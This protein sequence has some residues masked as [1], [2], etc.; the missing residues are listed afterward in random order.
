MCIYEVFTQSKL[1]I[2]LHV[3]WTHTKIEVALLST[4]NYDHKYVKFL[5]HIQRITSHNYYVYKVFTS[6]KFVFNRNRVKT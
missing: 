5:V 6:I 1:K 3:N 2:A 4:L